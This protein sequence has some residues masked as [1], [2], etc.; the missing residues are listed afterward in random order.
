[1]GRAVQ[2]QADQ[3]VG[4]YLVVLDEVVGQLVGL[5]VKL[6][7]GELILLEDQGDPLSGV[8]EGLLVKERGQDRSVFRIVNG[9]ALKS[10]SNWLFSL[11]LRG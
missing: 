6:A 8:F 9:R 11:A 1:V 3:V 10:V 2:Q 4:T 7:V 5:L